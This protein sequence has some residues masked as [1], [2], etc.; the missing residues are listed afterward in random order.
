M[1]LKG[2]QRS[3]ARQLSEHLL[4]E[5]DNDHVSLCELRGFVAD[6][7]H[8]ALAESHA[9]S[10]ATRCKQF[11]FSLS[12]NPPRQAEPTEAMLLRAADEAE[13]RLG[14]AGQPRAVVI[15]EKEGRRHA[16]VVWSRIDAESLKAINL[17]YFKRKLSGLSREL[18]LEHGWKL[19]DGLRRDGG[20]SPLNF[21]LEEWQQAKRLRLD[22][23]EIKQTFLDAWERSDGI[24][25]FSA[26]LAERG[27]FLAR[28]DRRGFV[29]LDVH[30]EVHAVARWCN[31]RTKDV[32]AKLGDPDHLP[33]VAEVEAQIA[34]KVTDKLRSFVQQVEEKH[35][36][37]LAPAVAAKAGL[38]R[39]QR[40]ER[41]AA[42]K[43]QKE[44]LEAENRDRAARLRKGLRGLWDV[45]TGKARTTRRQNEAELERSLT[46]DRDERDAMALAQIRARRAVQDRLDAIRAKQVRDRRIVEREIAARLRAARQHH[47]SHDHERTRRSDRTRGLSHD[48]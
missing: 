11:L 1:I 44:R 30:G 13:K 24:K 31:V 37:D 28:G 26:A 3:G 9:I 36:R 18:Y 46:R 43:R 29:A 33:G 20:R 39:D 23:Q 2:S 10:K 35:E 41:A 40:A 17:P 25:A 12:L 19:P 6:T 5:R 45:L 22:P 42:L 27:Y 34:G 7:L 4:N 38:I 15:H 16:H 32:K 8:G 47:D 14:L 48:R 21:S